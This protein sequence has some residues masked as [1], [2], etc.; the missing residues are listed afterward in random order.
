MRISKEMILSSEVTF[1][2]FISPD[3]F[4]LRCLVALHF[5]DFI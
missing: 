1:H 5:R 2:V 4:Q 3:F